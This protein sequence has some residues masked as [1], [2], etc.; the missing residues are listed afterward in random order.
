[1]RVAVFD[2]ETTTTNPYGQGVLRVLRGLG[3]E[4]EFTLYAAR[5]D[6]DGSAPVR[7]VRVPVLRRPLLALY[8]SFHVMAPLVALVDRRRHGSPDVVHSL[9][10]ALLRADVVGVQFSH[11]SYLRERWATSRPTGLRGLLR[12]AYER[13]AAA[14]EPLALS[15]AE[16]IVVPSRGLAQELLA[17]YP[18]LAGRVEVVPNAIDWERAQPPP[19]FDRAAVRAGAGL[20]VDRFTCV[21]VALGHY[22]RKG[23][24]LVLDALEHLGEEAPQLV[25]VGGEP[26]LVADYAERARRQGLESRV[27]FVGSQPDVRP[28]LWAADAFVFPSAYETFS[29][30][31]FEAAAAGLPLVVSDLYGV[32]DFLVPGHN[33]IAVERTA[34][35]VA[36]ALARLVALGP[37]ERRDLGTRASEAVRDYTE[38]RYVEG[39]RAAYERASGHRLAG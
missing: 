3:A 2:Y 12:G 32:Q 1:M 13:A 15:R 38:Q 25:V 9:E 35:S 17:E 26:D 23:L 24:P 22:E 36:A 10:S 18:H 11:R 33:G 6:D 39:W 28:F 7:W 14:L 19:G 5:F 4:H 29:Y 16:A 37:E 21:F 20:E 34:S 31:T 8:L 30:A 27:R